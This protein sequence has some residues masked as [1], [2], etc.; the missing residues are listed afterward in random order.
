MM[1]VNSSLVKEQDLIRDD[2][3]KFKSSSKEH[4]EWI[5]VQLEKSGSDFIV[6]APLSHFENLDYLSNR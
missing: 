2:I 1:P 5:I 6:R 3:L 4:T